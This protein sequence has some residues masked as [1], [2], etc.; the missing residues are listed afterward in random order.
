MENIDRKQKAFDLFCDG[1]NCAQSVVGAFADLVEIP[2]EQLMSMSI[3]FGGGF[4]RTRNICGAVSAMG[5]IV[6]ILTPSCGDPMKDKAVVYQQVQKLSNEFKEKNNSDNCAVLL[7]NVKNL[8]TGYIPQ[9]RDASYYNNRPCLKFVLDA[10]EI[11]ENHLI[12]N[13]I[14][15]NIG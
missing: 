6:G 9:V 11:L 4:G 15:N 14:I 12:E 3:A 5:I 10:V 1:H 7:S 2:F 8:T 13:G